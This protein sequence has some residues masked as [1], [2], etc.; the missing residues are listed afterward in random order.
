MTEFERRYLGVETTITGKKLGGYAA[1]FDSVTSLRGQFLERIAPTA[2]RSVLESPDLD[3]VALFN[4]DE[5]LLLART[6]NGSLR[7]S[8]DSRGLEFDMDLNL[9]TTLGNDVRAMVDSGLIQKCSFAFRVGAEEWSTHQ[10]QQLRTI[11]SFAELGDV[12]VVTKPAYDTTSVS[13]RSEPTGFT[14]NLY[15]Q[16][17]QIRA[18][19]L[20]GM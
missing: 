10:G 11:T 5:N 4:H 14:P 6:S 17:A 19:R 12:S 16:L 7:L 2:F 9:D 8:T 3:V 18:R 20:K 15:T 13:L 1:V